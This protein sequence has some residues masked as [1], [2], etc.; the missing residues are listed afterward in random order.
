MYKLISWI[1]RPKYNNWE[2]ALIED[3]KT[4]KQYITTGIY[5][6]EARPERLETCIKVDT[7]NIES[8]F[9]KWYVYIGG[10]IL[11]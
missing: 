3:I 11:S 5:K 8:F 2:G 10:K 4:G 6:W 1:K 7:I 9:D